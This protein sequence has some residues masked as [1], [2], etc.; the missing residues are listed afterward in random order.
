VSREWLLGCGS[1][2]YWDCGC[3][4]GLVEEGGDGTDGGH[5]R[6]WRSRAFVLAVVWSSRSLVE[7][8]ELKRRE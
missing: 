4:R 5:R 3:G 6:G 1:A 7:I 2:Q 8:E